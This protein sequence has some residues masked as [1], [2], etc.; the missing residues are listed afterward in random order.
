MENIFRY[1]AGVKGQHKQND[2]YVVTLPGPAW[3]RPRA[4]F[5]IQNSHRG[6]V[7]PFY[8]PLYGF[9]V[10]TLNHNKIQ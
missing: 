8:R 4:L 3:N 5:K 10:K 2:L 9:R 6:E 7:P 1:M